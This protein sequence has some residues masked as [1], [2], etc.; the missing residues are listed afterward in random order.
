MIGNSLNCGFVESP[1]KA[2][3]LP[4]P[5][6]PTLSKPSSLT[7]ALQDGRWYTFRA[8]EP[9]NIAIDSEN[10][11]STCSGRYFGYAMSKQELHG[12]PWLGPY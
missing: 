2:P 7:S 4:E 9:L 6:R 8:N 3:P 11:H 12:L 5:I 1:L 10:E